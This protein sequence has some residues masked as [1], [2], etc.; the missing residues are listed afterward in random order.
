MAASSSPLEAFC[1]LA[2]M[3]GTLVVGGMALYLYG[4]P[5]EKAAAMLEGITRRASELIEQGTAETSQVTQAPAVQPLGL[6]PLQSGMQAPQANFSENRAPSSHLDPN[7]SPATAE[8]ATLRSPD[9][10]PPQRQSAAA[11]SVSAWMQDPQLA[12]H[13]HEL[14]QLGAQLPKLEPWGTDGRLH[15]F[16]CSA[17]LPGCEAFQR[18]FDAIRPTPAEA[19]AVALAEL[20]E[21][22]TSHQ[23]PITR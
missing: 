9:L 19:V 12:S 14:Q 17:A 10:L 2:I 22:R 5:P 15:R 3:V 16:H 18:H 1:R 7:V 21:W 8:L 13:V 11:A 23:Q 20:R 6:A 4:P